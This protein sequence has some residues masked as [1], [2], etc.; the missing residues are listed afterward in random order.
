MRWTLIDEM[1]G[2]DFGMWT[3]QRWSG[4]EIMWRH[5]P[6]WGGLQEH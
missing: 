5:K 4:G 1:N 6:N 2:I 3:Q